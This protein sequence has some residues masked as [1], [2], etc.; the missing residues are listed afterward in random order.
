MTPSAPTNRP[1][2]LDRALDRVERLGNR[3][4]DPLVIFAGLFLIK[5]GFMAVMGMLLL[6]RNGRK[7]DGAKWF[8]KV[9]TAVSYIVVFLLLLLP[10]LPIAAVRTLVI[11]C[12]VVMLYTLFCY[13]PVFRKMWKE[14]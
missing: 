10:D 1:R 8:G 2:L 13:I 4:P 9:C 5:E 3:L 11:L 6:R 14:P 12:A 7:L